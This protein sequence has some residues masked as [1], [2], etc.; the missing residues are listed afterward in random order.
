MS[1]FNLLLSATVLFLIAAA[2]IPAGAQFPV[3]DGPTAERARSDAD[4]DLEGRIANMRYLSTLAEKAGTAR[5]K[6]PNLAV[7]E[8]QEDFTRLQI[9]NKDLVLTTSKSKDLDFKFVTK[10]ASEI[11]KRA[12][13]LQGNLAL[14]DSGT[15]GPR[16]VL[17]PITDLKQLKTAVTSLGWLIYWFKRN[18]IFNEVKV[19]EQHSAAKAR[20][21]LDKIIDLSLHLKKSSEHLRKEK[22]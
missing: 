2:A 10:C 6:D 4:S 17:L 5:K 13:R 22:R 1:A 7:E 19:I 18:P 21:D 15:A 3:A 9:V 8:L 20:N 16:A 11:N 14:P 12:E